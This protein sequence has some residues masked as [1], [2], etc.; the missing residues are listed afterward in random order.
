VYRIRIKETG[1]FLDETKGKWSNYKRR[2]FY[3]TLGKAR[4][5]LSQI[6]IEDA[7]E[8]VE[9]ELVEKRIIDANANRS[10]IAIMVES[11]PDEHGKSHNA[12]YCLRCA[13]KYGFWRVEG[14]RRIQISDKEF[15]TACSQQ[16]RR[17]R[18]VKQN[19]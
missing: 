13:E 2:Q 1:Q 11:P 3:K 12:Y 6:G 19:D 9:F 5:A 4:Q 10:P 18:K 8:I 7:C 14:A 17:E 16:I 15:C